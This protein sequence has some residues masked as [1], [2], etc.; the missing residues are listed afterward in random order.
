MTGYWIACVLYVSSVMVS[1]IKLNFESFEQTFGEDSM[2]CDVRVRKFNRTTSVLNGTFHIL[3]DVSNEVQY[4]LDMYYSRLGNQQYNQLPMK[5]PSAGICDFIANLYTVYPEITA[6]FVNF[7]VA[8]ECPITVRDMHVFD[9][10][11]PSE[12]WPVVMRKAGLWKLA[13]NG[14]FQG[15]PRL[16]FSF[17]LRATNE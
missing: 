5:L 10:E 16:A 9:R 17:T 6:M 4:Q 15:K 1:C 11:F 2:L 12:I 3:H 14:V 8:N 13:V 7:P